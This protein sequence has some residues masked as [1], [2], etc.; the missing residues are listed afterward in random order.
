MLIDDVAPRSGNLGVSELWEDLRQRFPSFTFDQGPG[1]G[2]LAVGPG[3]A[4]SIEN[5]VKADATEIERIRSFFAAPRD[6][7]RGNFK[8]CSMTRKLMRRDS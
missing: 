7:C 3:A 8:R 1:L 6:E 4:S 2:V 5:L